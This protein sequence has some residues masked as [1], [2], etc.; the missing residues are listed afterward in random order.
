MRVLHIRR[1]RTSYT[2]H[3]PREREDYTTHVRPPAPAP[4]AQ[5][6]SVPHAQVHHTTRDPKY[7]TLHGSLRSPRNGRDETLVEERWILERTQDEDESVTRTR[8]ETLFS[9]RAH[10]HPYALRVRR[11]STIDIHL[12]RAYPTLSFSFE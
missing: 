5:S 3:R 9:A 12:P 8:S 1:R 11:L 2:V 7:N 4:S 6:P 10:A